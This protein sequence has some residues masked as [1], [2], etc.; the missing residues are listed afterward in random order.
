MSIHR[1]PLIASSYN[2]RFYL[3]RN[4]I[5]INIPYISRI[6]CAFEIN[7]LAD[8][9]FSSICDLKVGWVTIQIGY[10]LSMYS[11]IDQLNA[12]QVIINIIICH[13]E[14]YL[15]FSKVLVVNI[16]ENTWELHNWIF[17]HNITEKRIISDCRD[18]CIIEYYIIKNKLFV[19]NSCKLALQCNELLHLT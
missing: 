3:Y 14:F 17:G 6:E 5:F 9:H 1:K 15:K 7:K 11:F 8:V 19:L 13:W 10:Q 16:V 12:R 4:L 2:K 18:K